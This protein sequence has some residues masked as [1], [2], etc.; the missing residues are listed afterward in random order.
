MIIQTVR[1]TPDDRR[2]LMLDKGNYSG[3]TRAGLLAKL[4]AT[5]QKRSWWE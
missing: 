4:L 3:E 2:P 5:P 1:E